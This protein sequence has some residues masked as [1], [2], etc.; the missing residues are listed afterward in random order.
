MTRTYNIKPKRT[1][2]KGTNFRSRLE[3]RWAIYFDTLGIKWEYEPKNHTA[4]G[5]YYNVDFW[6]PVQEAYA[7]VKPTEPTQ[8]E[9]T[10]LNQLCDY[11]KRTGIMLIGKPQTGDLQEW[12]FSKVRTTLAAFRANKHRFK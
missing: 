4:P 12:E 9:W 5:L 10:K 7:E 11:N 8:E 6:L 2:Y 1:K 3:A